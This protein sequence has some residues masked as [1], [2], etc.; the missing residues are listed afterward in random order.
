MPLTRVGRLGLD[1]GE[2]SLSR[3]QRYSFTHSLTG[4]LLHNYLRMHAVH[5]VALLLTPRRPATL[6]RFLLLF[7]LLLLLTYIGLRY[8]GI[9][10]IARPQSCEISVQNEPS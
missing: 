7:L 1:N 9:I 4:Q 3:L 10:M 5:R 6:G 8:V 2:R